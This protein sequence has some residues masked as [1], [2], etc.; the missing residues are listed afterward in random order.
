MP[1]YHWPS[2]RWQNIFLWQ[3]NQCFFFF[4]VL[5]SGLSFFVCGDSNTHSDQQPTKLNSGSV[6][7]TL[8]IGC[9]VNSSTITLFVHVHTVTARIGLSSNFQGA[10]WRPEFAFR[11]KVWIWLIGF[12]FKNNLDLLNDIFFAS[13]RNY[14]VI[15]AKNK[16][17]N[18]DVISL[19]SN[20]A[21]NIE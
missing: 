18:E 11:V 20:L 5:F 10:V 15:C 9:Q 12:R 13:R 17:W 3:I 1:N 19:Y 2:T 7:N 6:S 16:I 21:I 8:L 14:R 4:R